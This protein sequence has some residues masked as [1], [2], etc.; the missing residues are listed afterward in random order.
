MNNSFVDPPY[1]V[2][3]TEVYSLSILWVSE[4][5]YMVDKVVR[6]KLS[7]LCITIDMILA[8]G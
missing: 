1:N 2:K 4:H 7:Q 5:E 3:V 8:Q 6:S